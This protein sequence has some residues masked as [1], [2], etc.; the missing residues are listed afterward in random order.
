M[1]HFDRQEWC[2]NLSLTGGVI[3]YHKPA[4]IYLV[5]LGDFLHGVLLFRFGG[6]GDNVATVVVQCMFNGGSG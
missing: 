2:L 6:H 5:V 4:V 1:I 3:S